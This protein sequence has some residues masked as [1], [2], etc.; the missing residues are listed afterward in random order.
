[1][2]TDEEKQVT[3]DA[4]NERRRDA[5]AA[6]KVKA[7][8]E[9]LMTDVAT[10]S[11]GDTFTLDEVGYVVLSIDNPANHIHTNLLEEEETPGTHGSV[12]F[13]TMVDV[14]ARAEAEKATVKKEA[15]VSVAPATA[16]PPVSLDTGNPAVSGGRWFK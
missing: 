5:A 1:M 11:P 6:A 16:A 2:K 15:V 9:E 12:D 4:R 14:I 7:E 13:G 10:L 3:K 8:A